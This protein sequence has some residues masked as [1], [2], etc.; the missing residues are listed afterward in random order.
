[1]N[2]SYGIYEQDGGLE[3]FATNKIHIE[4][5]KDLTLSAPPIDGY[6]FSKWLI[7][8]KEYADG[9]TI[10]LTL[11]RSYV[12]GQLTIYHYRGGSLSEMDGYIYA[13]YNKDKK[14]LA[15]GTMITLADG[16]QKPVELLTGN[17]QLLVWNLK[18]G[19]FDC[20]PILFIDSDAAQFYEVI[21]LYFSD[22]TSVEVISEHAFWDINLNKYVTLSYDAEQYVGHWFNKQTTNTG[23]ALGWTGVQLINVEIREEYTS[24][25]SPVTYGHLCYYVNGMLSM[26]GGIE[27]LY[28]IFEVD[29]ELMKYDTAAYEADIAAYGLFTYEEF[30]ELYDIPELMFDACGGQYLKVAIGKGLLDYSTL[31]GLVERY[32]AFFEA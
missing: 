26:P 13:I 32:G 1:M 5:G 25:W 24:A 30:C 10:N 6:T 28:N 20:A 3:P 21:N 11:H 29:A 9:T 7:N 4:S 23:G 15:E 17:E 31:S 14:C 12:T 8:N 27:G 16:S 18:T 2:Y 22:G 19:S